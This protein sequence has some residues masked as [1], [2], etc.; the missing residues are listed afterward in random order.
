MKWRE[1]G[2]TP[3]PS[4]AWAQASASASAR[5]SLTRI[6]Y[7]FENFAVIPGIYSDDNPIIAADPRMLSLR[8]ELALELSNLLP[9]DVRPSGLAGPS[10]VVRDFWR[11][12]N[13]P[14][15][16]MSPMTI[17]PVSNEPLRAELKLASGFV[18]S[19]HESIAKDLAKAM[20]GRI[21]PAP[22]RIRK[23]A[24]TGFPHFTT[25]IVVKKRILLEQIFPNVDHFLSLFQLG[26]T[27]EL[28][29]QFEV[30]V[31]GYIGRRTQ[32]DKVVHREDGSFAAK[33]R[34][35]NSPEYARSGGATGRRFE[36]DKSVTLAGNVVPDMFA[37]R[38]RTV[39]GLPFGPNY[40]TTALFTPMR[41]H[42]LNEYAFTWKHRGASDLTEKA[43]R[44]TFALGTDVKQFDQSVPT[45]MLDF[46]VNSLPLADSAK[47][48]LQSLL[49]AP[50]FQPNPWLGATELFDPWFG[51]PGDASTWKLDVGLPSGVGPNPDIGKFCMTFAYL[52]FLDDLTQQVAGRVGEILR[53]KDSRMAL[54]DAS[55]DAVL[56]FNDEP[57]YL[58]AKQR[59]DAGTASPYF[60]V[61]PEIGVVFLGNVLCD[62]ENGRKF[63]P[64]IE[65]WVVNMLVPEHPLP[66][67]FGTGRGHR[68]YAPIGYMERNKLY[69]DAPKFEEVYSCYDRLHRH[70]FDMGADAPWLAA[71][72]RL[73]LP[74]LGNLSA[75]DLEAL[76]NPGALYYK[77]DP[78]DVS[79]LVL[80]ELVASIPFDVYWPMIGHLYHGS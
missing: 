21:S 74:D 26:K 47:A 3:P 53:G 45:W 44:F 23:A 19:R 77:V 9:V 12:H 48:L 16:Y 57:L 69:S 49:H 39:Y 72:R 70:H 33:P 2:L 59:V 37:M 27:E 73:K 54:L 7:N 11:L 17:P 24:S 56:L 31:A 14:G 34:E 4:V 68:E 30:V 58:A 13:Q 20:F 40:L 63:V 28:A 29:S 18:S 32:P 61:E 8:R 76:L 51:D 25:D 15:F 80:D 79:P 78:K 64:N 35:V 41:A 62:A 60:A 50:Y 55:D 1:K 38:Q 10:A 6:S 65:T 71:S 52:A 43:S 67:R 66:A 22:L 5:R 46:I 75:A 36:A 42:Y